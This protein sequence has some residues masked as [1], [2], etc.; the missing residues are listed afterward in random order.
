MILLPL[1]LEMKTKAKQPH[2]G[3]V[4]AKR[5]QLEREWK[6]EFLKECGAA[7]SQKIPNHD[8]KK[9]VRIYKIT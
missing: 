1:S 5:K 9:S 6:N 8:V 3:S 4:I 7:T 2:Y